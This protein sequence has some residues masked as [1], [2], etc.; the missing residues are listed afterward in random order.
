MQAI[1]H[2]IEQD[3]TILSSNAKA[4]MAS[5]QGSRWLMESPTFVFMCNMTSVRTYVEL[6][7]IFLFKRTKTLLEVLI[8]PIK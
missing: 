8:T 4:Q 1:I 6:R 5:G 7:K 3:L 2:K